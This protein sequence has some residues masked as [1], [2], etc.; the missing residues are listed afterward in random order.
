MPKLI[1]I[2]CHDPI[3][4]PN[5]DDIECGWVDVWASF[6][7]KPGRC[8]EVVSPC[9]IGK[10]SLM[11]DIELEKQFMEAYPQFASDSGVI[12]RYLESVLDKLD[13]SDVVFDERY[14]LN[15]YTRDAVITKTVA[16]R[17]VAKYLQA[18]YGFESVRFKWKKPRLITIPV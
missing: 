3:A 16:E 9:L 13:T 12:L 4:I 14:A 10:D 6:T 18:K 5:R 7:K 2:D 17:A 15:I 11:S 1:K 8:K